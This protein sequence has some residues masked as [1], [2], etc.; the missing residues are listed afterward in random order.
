LGKV[1]YRVILELLRFGREVVA[2]EVN[3]EGRFIEEVKSLGVVPVIIGDA[4]RS[5]FLHKAGVIYADAILPATDD[6]LANLEIALDAREINPDLKVVMRMFDVELAR[7]VE[8]GFGIH[9]NLQRGLS[10]L[11]D[12]GIWKWR[13]P[14]LE[15][16]RNC[17][18]NHFIVQLFYGGHSI[19]N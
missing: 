18:P 11:G 14:L 10:S 4:T 17:G 15:Y 6:Q 8:K 12:R 13:E 9:K 7:K 3:E 2:I 19:Q 5:E 1:G 16:F